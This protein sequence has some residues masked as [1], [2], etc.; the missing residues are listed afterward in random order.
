MISSLGPNDAAAGSRHNYKNGRLI[1]SNIK[2]FYGGFPPSDGEMADG[3]KHYFVV[4]AAAGH[5]GRGAARADGFMRV[6]RSKPSKES[7]E[8]IVFYLCSSMQLSDLT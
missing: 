5:R 6:V 1:G 7:D 2:L 4:R 8:A 3:E